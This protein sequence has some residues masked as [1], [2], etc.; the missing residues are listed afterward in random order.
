M[1]PANANIGVIVGGAVGGSVVFAAALYALR[2]R[3]LKMP[4]VN[5]EPSPALKFFA[6][7]GWLKEL[8]R[9]VNIVRQSCPPAR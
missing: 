9:R 2:R 8:R 7:F 1:S 4:Q 5:V 3:M 6:K